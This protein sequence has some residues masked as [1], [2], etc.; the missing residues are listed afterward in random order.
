MYK[1][2]A[3]RKYEKIGKGGGGWDGKRI[4]ICRI[5]GHEDYLLFEPHFFCGCVSLFHILIATCVLHLGGVVTAIVLIAVDEDWSVPVVTSYADWR[6]RD[7]TM[8]GCDDRN[9]FITPVFGEVPGRVSLMGL[10][11]AFHG[12][13]FTWQ[14]IVVCGVPGAQKMYTEELKNER[15]WLRW[16]EY[17]LS[18]PLMT[19]VIAIIF[20]VVD[21]YLLAVLAICTSGLQAFGYAQ[22]IFSNTTNNLDKNIRF[23]PIIA[24]SV[25]FL[26]YWSVVGV[27]FIESVSNSRSKPPANMTIAIWM[28]FFVMTAL[29]SCFGIVLAVDVAKRQRD[30]QY[31][32]IEGAYCILSATSKWALG[33][34]LIWVI[35]IRETQIQLEFVFSPSC[36]TTRAATAMFRNATVADGTG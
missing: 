22:E 36:D 13:S 27:A 10:V 5:I 28:T 33:A 19:I 4:I 11:A 16:A 12:L 2:R 3:S 8:G 21:V 30:Y 24:G 29:F 17:A 20:G 23:F 15:N 31:V 18:A 32:Y 25:F 14:F 7:P 6:Q 9:C 26:A 34:L 35:W 1:G